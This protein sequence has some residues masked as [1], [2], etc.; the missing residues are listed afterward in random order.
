[1]LDIYAISYINITFCICI[2]CTSTSGWISVHRIIKYKLYKRNLLTLW[3]F[4]ERL[5]MY[6]I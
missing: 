1:M 3:E 4:L 5:Q 6:S 2:N